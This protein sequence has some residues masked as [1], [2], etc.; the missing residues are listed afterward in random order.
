MDY[1]MMGHNVNLA[2]RLEGVN[3]LYGTWILI[4][5]QTYEE[6]YDRDKGIKNFTVRKLDRVRVVGV[7]Q[8][9]RL[10]ELVDHRDTVDRD[11]KM[12]HKL[13]TFNS[14]LTKFEEKDWEGAK[15]LFEEVLGEFPEDG[16]SKLYLKRTTDFLKKPPRPDWDGV[17]NMESK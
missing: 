3:K 8:P 9:I 11:Q 2:A 7:N 14:G 13:R 1:T 5:E 10:Y 16:P 4:S 15:E 12:I 6:T 17:Y